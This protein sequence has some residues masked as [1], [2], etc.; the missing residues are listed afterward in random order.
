[1]RS[2]RHPG[3][4]KKLARELK[5]RGYKVEKEIVFKHIYHN[6]EIVDNKKKPLF[7][8]WRI[9]GKGIDGGFCTPNKQSYKS[10]S[11]HITA[12]NVDCF[13][14]WS[15]CPLRMKI[16]TLDYEKLFKE[17]E[18]LGSPEGFEISNNFDEHGV[19]TYEQVLNENI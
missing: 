15:K 1:M 4:Y 2:K 5:N 19:F 13:D 8:F 6:H 12:D 16:Q 10:L 7:T 18:L 17:L 3:N 14:K 11:G 9:T